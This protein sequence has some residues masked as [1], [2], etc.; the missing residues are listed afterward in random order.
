MTDPNISEDAVARALRIFYRNY[1]G[2]VDERCISPISVRFGATE[3]HPE[4]QWLL[5]AHDH[6]RRAE[7]EFALADF[8]SIGSVEDFQ[9]VF[10]RNAELE[11]ELK[12]ADTQGC[13]VCGGVVYVD[14]DCC[15]ACSP[16]AQMYPAA[17]DQAMME[18]DQTR[19]LELFDHVAG[20]IRQGNASEAMARNVEF[21]KLEFSKKGFDT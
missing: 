16:E 10:A 12:P 5:L 7:R 13:K 14:D 8:M 4:H 20:C 11:A 1:R 19:V 6:D 3:W 21:L 15:P 2:E 9:K 18:V 17:P